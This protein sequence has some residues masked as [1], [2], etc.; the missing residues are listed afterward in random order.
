[1]FKRLQEKWNV[2]GWK[3]LLILLTFAIGGS[4]TG[5]VGKRIMGL[6]GIDNPVLY[7]VVYI[8]LVTLIWPVMVLIVSVFSGQF[9]FFRQYIA[10][11]GNKIFRR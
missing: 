11:L 6:F 9:P 2:T 5:Y 1:M 4:L 3:L 8:P 7:L 10:K